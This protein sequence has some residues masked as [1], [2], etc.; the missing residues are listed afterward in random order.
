MEMD[1]D[2][3]M[4]GSKICDYYSPEQIQ[5]AG[6]TINLSRGIIRDITRIKD[7][8]RYDQVVER[9]CVWATS[10]L[11]RR[12]TFQQIGE[13]DSFFFFGIEE[14][15]YCIRIKKGGKKVV[16]AG[17]SQIWHKKGASAKKLDMDK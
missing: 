2:I 8:K 12:E 11:F 15:D 6:G 10:A 17:T 5:C 9:D 13:L 1:Q 7:S 3:A 4:A 14:Y 16:Y